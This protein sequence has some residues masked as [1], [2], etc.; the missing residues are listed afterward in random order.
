MFGSE[1]VH[2]PV[3]KKCIYAQSLINSMSICQHVSGSNTTLL[4][5][6]FGKAFAT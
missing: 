1:L 6:V 2:Q 4:A 5:V 3:V